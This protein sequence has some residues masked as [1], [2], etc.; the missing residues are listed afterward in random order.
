MYELRPAM[1]GALCA[2]LLST[3]VYAQGS[4]AGTVRDTSGAVLPGVTVEASST[5]LIEK[6]RAVVTDTTGQYKIVDLRPGTYSVTFSLAGFTT[7]K[8]EG[9]ELT[10]S[11]AAPLSVV[12]TV[13]S[14]TET[15]TVTGAAPAV[16]VQ[17]VAQQR[18]L[19]AAVLDALPAGRSHVDDAL[20]LPGLL[21][22]Q[23]TV[24]SGN[25]VDVGGTNNLQI[26][27]M[28]IHGSRQSDTRTLV[29]GVEIRN[30]A[31]EGHSTNF[32][33]DMGSTQEVTLNYAASS[34]ETMTGGLQINNIPR[35][36]GNLFKGSMFATGVNSW[37]QGNNYSTDLA[38]RGL[39]SPNSLRL[40]YDVNPAFGGP[41]LVDRLW[42][43]G[44][45]RWQANKSYIAG[46]YPN[47][48][49][50]NPDAWLYA[51]D[52]SRRVSDS[53]TQ[54][55]GSIRL[56]WQADARNK[57]GFYFEKQGRDWFN[58][59][60]GTSEESTIHYVFPT[61]R[62]A[63]LGWS[64]P[65]TSRL[66]L[67]GRYSYHAEVYYQPVPSD[68][69]GSLIP[70]TEQSNGLNYRGVSV[71]PT[72]FGISSAPNIHQAV[73]S[74]SYVTGAHALKIGF[75]DLWG[76]QDNGARDNSSS[77]SYRFNN[78]VPNLITER[79]TPY[80]NLNQLQAELG[81]YAQ[82]KW[83][84]KKLTL[85]GG[86]RFDYFS[87]YFPAQTVGPGTLVPTRNLA[88][89]ETPWYSYKDLN[90][91][92]GVVYDLLGNGKTAIKASLGRF[93]LA[94]NPTTGNPVLNLATSV[95]R[96]WT[97]VNRNF[98]PDCDLLNPSA[99]GGECGAIS[100]ST[101][102]GLRP[103]TSYDPATLSGWRTRP[104]NW[105]FSTSVQRQIAPRVGVDVGYYRRWYTNQTVTQNLAVAATDFGLFG[106]TAPLD[107][108]L[109]GGGGYVTNGFYN[110]NPDKVGAVNNYITFA[111]GF[112]GLLEHWNGI[113]ATVNLRLPPAVVLQGGLSSGRTSTDSCAIVNSYL[114][115]ITVASPIGAVQTIDMCHLDTPFLTQ[116]KLLGSYTV[117]RVDVRV[118]ATFQSFPGPLVAANYVATNAQV[119]QSLGRPLSGGAANVTVNL[120]APGT[121]YGDRV[122]ELDVRFTKLL[123]VGR[124]RTS[125]NLDLA[126]A[127]N[128]NAVLVQNNNFATWQVPQ[129]IVNAR[130]FK[131][132]VQVDF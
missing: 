4:I 61:S 75:S 37:F 1:A 80:D 84:I 73:G 103:S 9:I 70:V 31:N 57:F 105:E 38:Q 17:S 83:T 52:T 111:D 48:N 77:L 60:A 132:S 90:P 94:G 58:A 99:N 62:M 118:A 112:G 107:P 47:L 79:S 115:A 74:L 40:S 95:T 89:P 91:R 87:T 55:N 27:W 33:P 45:A 92:I 53:V 20:L 26:A 121:M 36:G 59:R 117:P 113:D 8:R 29:D 116:V 43:F 86:L 21:A 16:D 120:V 51:P 25:L 12:L 63:T 50:G 39:T 88:F 44:S 124:I 34:A 114:G 127:L 54:E 122:N 81:I 76:R 35:E 68:I 65:L 101:F 106:V 23:P 130:L 100:D 97:D 11:F 123:K 2:V 24:G 108:R 10:G 69:F 126:N 13:G 71:G 128:T 131:I 102:G 125:T 67:E 66:L 19:D 46:L 93:V 28:S 32:V 14:V 78:G 3:A 110:L 98:I 109:P 15:L 104:S 22:I 49:A 56:T 85:N 7:M 41:L 30:L 72:P 82:D 96:T 6:V 5:A 64:A 18:V 42:F 119:Q 129:S